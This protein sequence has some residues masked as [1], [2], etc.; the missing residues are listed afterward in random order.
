[1]LGIHAAS[2]FFLGILLLHLHLSFQKVE[3]SLEGATSGS[4]VFP[5]K[6]S[7]V[8]KMWDRMVSEALV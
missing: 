2:R 4:Q 6:S 8:V 3:V 7:S 5:H 1:M